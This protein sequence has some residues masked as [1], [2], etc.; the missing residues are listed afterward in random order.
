M[1]GSSKFWRELRLPSPTVRSLAL[2]GKASL[3][4]VLIFLVASAHRLPAPIFETADKPPPVPGTSV[5]PDGSRTLYE[6][7]KAHR[8]AQATVS[9]RDG[10]LREKISYELDSAGRFASRMIFDA[11]GK[12]RS[13]SFYKYDTSGRVLEETQLGRDDAVLHKIAYSYDASG[14]RSYSLFDGN[15]KLLNNSV[16][17]SRTPPK[18]AFG[19]GPPGG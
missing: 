19:E 3:L 7:D 1:N 11:D 18:P 10:K 8:R 5:N 14:K 15:G 12:L 9:E 16:S 6:V 2:R 4:F 17:P 13:K